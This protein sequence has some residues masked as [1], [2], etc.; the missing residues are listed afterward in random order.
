[1]VELQSRDVGGTFAAFK[2]ETYSEVFSDQVPLGFSMLEYAES[3]NWDTATVASS[4]RRKASNPHSATEI[5]RGVPEL[6]REAEEALEKAAG[7]AASTEVASD[8]GES[9]PTDTAGHSIYDA[10][11]P[12]GHEPPAWLFPPTARQIA[13]SRAGALPRLSSLT[14]LSPTSQKQSTTFLPTWN[15]NPTATAQ[16]ASVLEAAKVDLTALVMRIEK[17]REGERSEL[18]AKLDDQAR[19]YAAKLMD[20]EIEAQDKLDRQTKYREKL[21]N[22][23]QTQTDLINDLQRRWILQ[24]RRRNPGTLAD[25]DPNAD[26]PPISLHVSGAFHREAASP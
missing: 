22:E 4:R 15:T 20:L 9:S 1:M 12:V 8:E 17:V 23:L 24:T 5:S 14:P 7:S 11:L 2:N 21:E 10:P 13:H 6:M 16:A 25:S 19:E 3:H 26:S 18:E